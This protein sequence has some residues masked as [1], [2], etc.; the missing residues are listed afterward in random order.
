MDILDFFRSDAGFLV[1]IVAGQVFAAMVLA[2]LRYRIM[3]MQAAA[4][5]DVLDD[6]QDHT[7][8]DDQDD[9]G[10]WRA[11]PPQRTRVSGAVR[12][13]E[14]GQPKPRRSRKRD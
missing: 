3:A 13:G 4:Q 2:G 9:D 5:D 14:G 1:A 7:Q 10:V 12:R 6:D 11:P 8:D